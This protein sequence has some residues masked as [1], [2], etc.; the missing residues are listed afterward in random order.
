MGGY[1]KYVFAL[2]ILGGLGGA[3][4]VPYVLAVTPPPKGSPPP[5]LGALMVAS[6]I[7]SGIL[8]CGLS[9]FGTS[10]FSG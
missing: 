4:L 5:N 8:A 2:G 6:G 7:S 9:H 10:P 1:L 3:L